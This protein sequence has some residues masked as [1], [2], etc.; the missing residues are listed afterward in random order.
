MIEVHDNNLPSKT[1]E[2]E[3]VAKQQALRFILLTEVD[4]ELKQKYQDLTN[5]LERKQSTGEDWER[6]VLDQVIPLAKGVG[7]DFSVGD[8]RE[9]LQLAHRQLTDEE[10]N[11]AVGGA[12]QIGPLSCE[13]VPDKATFRARLKRWY[14]SE[15]PHF[16]RQW[17]G[18]VS[19]TCW[20]C[21]HLQGC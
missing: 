6:I 20:D 12:A 8:F 2:G 14:D 15:C 16:S 13:L 5:Q 18:T 4:E 9:M 19:T 1:N 11:R 10:L 3:A 21:K 17:D 7:F